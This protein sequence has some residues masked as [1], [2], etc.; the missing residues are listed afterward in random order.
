MIL[1]NWICCVVNKAKG[2][3][4]ICV[5]LR[6]NLSDGKFKSLLGTLRDFFVSEKFIDSKI[7]VSKAIPPTVIT[8]RKASGLH[9]LAPRDDLYDLLKDL[10][11]H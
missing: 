5:N 2:I 11:D 9:G 1:L 3:L 8:R 4:G 7:V 6:D 10:N